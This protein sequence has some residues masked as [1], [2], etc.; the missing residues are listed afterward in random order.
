MQI[1]QIAR[2]SNQDEELEENMPGK[3]RKMVVGNTSI[4]YFCRLFRSWNRK[5]VYGGRP[6]KRDVFYS[7]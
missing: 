7:D 5:E 6:K 4:F 3:N 1:W 2:Q